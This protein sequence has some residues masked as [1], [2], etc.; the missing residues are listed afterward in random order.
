MDTCLP[1]E[2]YENLAASIA[3]EIHGHEDVKKA[4]LLMMVGGEQLDRDDGM[5]IRG[6]I[7]VALIGDPGIAKSQL[8]K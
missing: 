1:E 4:M 7:N 2:F 5:H 8:L 3:P 6:D